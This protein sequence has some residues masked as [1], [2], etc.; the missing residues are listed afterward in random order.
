MVR[1]AGIPPPHAQ[2]AADVA[3]DK[4]QETILISVTSVLVGL[5]WLFFLNRVYVKLLLIRKVSWDDGGYLSK[6]F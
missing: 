2:T 3:S 1:P 4:V 5:M 6:N